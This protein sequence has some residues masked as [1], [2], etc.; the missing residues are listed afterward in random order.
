MITGKRCERK[1]FSFS[2]LCLLSNMQPLTAE[3]SSSP[4]DGDQRQTRLIIIKS[5]FAFTPS[6]HIMLHFKIIQRKAIQRKHQSLMLHSRRDFKCFAKF[7]GRL[8]LLRRS[9]LSI[10][11]QELNI[12]KQASVILNFQSFYFI[13]LMQ[14][15]HPICV[16]H[17]SSL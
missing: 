2:L 17:S 15:C 9:E 13:L 7:K 8:F 12:Y 6:K 14:T 16:C 4:L 3:A 5:S 10:S 1:R 11:C